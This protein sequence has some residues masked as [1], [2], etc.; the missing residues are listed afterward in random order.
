[1]AP[2]HL[3]VP[4]IELVEV[5]EGNRKHRQFP[6]CDSGKLMPNYVLYCPVNDSYISLL[7]IQFNSTSM[8]TFSS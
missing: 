6:S 3:S 7:A 4:L 2:E 1:M 8:C 5:K